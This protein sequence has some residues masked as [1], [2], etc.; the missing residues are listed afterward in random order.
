MLNTI[1]HFKFI[2]NF[3]KITNVTIQIVHLIVYSPNCK[4]KWGDM[5]AYG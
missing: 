1:L 5:W 3:K 4:K 2:C